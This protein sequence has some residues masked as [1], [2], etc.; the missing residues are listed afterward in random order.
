MLYSILPQSSKSFSLTAPDL[1]PILRSLLFQRGIRTK[2]DID[3]FLNP[4]Y[5]NSAYDPFQFLEMKKAVERLRKAAELNE[6]II[7]YGD[8]DVDG[9]TSSYILYECITR[10]LK[11]KN[12]SIQYPNRIKEGYGMKKLHIDD[13]KQK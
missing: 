8:Y 4:R 10:F 5:E 3:E 11:Y 2:D 6:R 9:I 1:H 13:M 12:I 7:I